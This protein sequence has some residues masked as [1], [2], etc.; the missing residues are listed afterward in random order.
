MKIEA[1]L[2][3]TITLIIF[4]VIVLIYLISVLVRIKRIKRK[5]NYHNDKKLDSS[6]LMSFAPFI[7]LTS[8]GMIVIDFI[9]AIL[10]SSLIGVSVVMTNKMEEL[11][12]E[13]LNIIKGDGQ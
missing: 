8:Q 6:Y 4:I 1:F 12:K 7:L 10:L 5:I 11:N 2:A 13:L 3:I 9:L